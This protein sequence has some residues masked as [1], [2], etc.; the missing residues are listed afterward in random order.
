MRTTAILICLCMALPLLPL[1]QASAQS[2]VARD[3]TAG[4][5]VANDNRV[6]A[7]TLRDGVLELHLEARLA[8]WRPH[9][10]GGGAMTVMAFAEQDGI[11]SIPGP[12]LRVP[13]G[14]EV[15][16]TVYNPFTDSVQIGLP[17]P[18][19]RREGLRSV[20][21]PVLV[22]H[23]LR[24]GTVADDTL[25]VEP[26]SVREVRF[27]AD[28]PGTYLYWGAL[29]DAT[30]KERTGRD[31]QLTGAIVVDPADAPPD[32]DDRVFVITMIDAFS[33]S[34]R[35]P[36]GDDLFAPAINGLS[37]PHTERLQHATGDSVRWRWLNGSGFDHPMHLH[38]FHFRTLARGDG[39]GDTAYSQNSVRHVVTELLEPGETVRMEWVPT[40]P[41]NWLMHCH[42]VTHIIPAEPPDEAERAHDLRDVTRH[43][44]TA[45]DGLVVGISV[46]D[47]HGR[48]AELPPPDQRLRLVART[49]ASEG[50]DGMAR[51]FV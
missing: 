50:T 4:A 24:A 41:G 6:P 23:G 26:G 31:S 30:L 17:P 35:T 12:L 18:R 8:T 20:V 3:D 22:M 37:W 38:G 48:A 40:R 43:P 29:S 32:P 39:S 1:R 25:L 34:S 16:V 9:R 5:A 19:H 49:K 46:T 44:L 2:T 42:F 28:R 10:D 33:D 27:R 13:A 15:R 21:D 51:G 11:A 45:M 7:G 36:A 14:T 47:E